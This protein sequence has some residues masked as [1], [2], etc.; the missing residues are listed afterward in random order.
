MMKIIIARR[1][2]RDPVYPPPLFSA[3]EKPMPE[4]VK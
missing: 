4:I 1:E 2:I 3:S